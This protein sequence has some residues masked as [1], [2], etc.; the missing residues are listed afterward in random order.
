MALAFQM[1]PRC[2]ANKPSASPSRMGRPR[3]KPNKRAREV[4]AA[5][6]GASKFR[7]HPEGLGGLDDLLF[8]PCRAHHKGQRIP[9]HLCV[10]D[11]RTFLKVTGAAGAG[12]VLT[13]WMGCAPGS[14]ESKPTASAFGDETF[15]LPPLGF[16]FDALSPAIDMATMEIHH[17]KHHAGYV[18]KLN[19][20]LEGRPMSSDGSLEALL[21]EVQPEDSALRNNGG[22]HFNH[23]LYWE[24]MR[25]GGPEAPEG[26][27]AELLRRDLGG[28][29]AFVEAFAKAGATQFGSGWAWL[30]VNA[31]GQLAV[32]ST[33]NQDNPLMAKCAEETGTPILGMDVWE[34]AYYLNYQNRRKDYIEAFLGLVNWEA[35]S[36]RLETAL[37]QVR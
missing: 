25:P 10:M 12:I 37:P 16:A 32:S 29:E 15:T 8:T 21:A 18:R 6:M 11:K 3:I 9:F 24:V 7:A 31:E 5:D 22:G 35:V 23:T 26:D 14:T 20:A 17:G 1:S 28:V 19:A 13:P 36:A 27:L 34:H 33:P 30:M 2:Q 4:N